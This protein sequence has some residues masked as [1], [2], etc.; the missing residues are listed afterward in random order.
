MQKFIDKKKNLTEEEINE[1]LYYYQQGIEIGKEE[2]INSIIYQ[3]NDLNIDIDIISK[4]TNYEKDKI[5]QIL[6]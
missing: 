1:L 6:T 4:I 5:L 3:L 2:T